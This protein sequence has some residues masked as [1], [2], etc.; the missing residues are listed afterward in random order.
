MRFAQ[1]TVHKRLEIDSPVEPTFETWLVF[2]D[3]LLAMTP[4]INSSADSRPHT[5]Q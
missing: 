3:R 4:V 1:W 5:H 2:E